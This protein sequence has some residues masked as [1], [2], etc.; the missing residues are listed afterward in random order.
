MIELFS[1]G[2][3]RAADSL[4]VL[5]SVAA[6]STITTKQVDS[7]TTSAAGI[8][9]SS[10][11]QSPFVERLLKRTRK[12]EIE[13]LC[14]NG[15]HPLL[16]DAPAI[17]SFFYTAGAAAGRFIVQR[18]G[19]SGRFAIMTSMFDRRESNESIRGFRDNL[20]T[21]QYRW[22]QVNIITCQQNPHAFEYYKRMSRFGNRTIWFWADSCEHLVDEIERI[23]K[24]NYF[25]AIKLDV[26]PCKISKENNALM[27]AI[28]LKDYQHMGYLAVCELVNPKP[29]QD[30]DDPPNIDCGCRIKQSTT[31]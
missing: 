15:R 18:F 23:K 3:Q 9:V 30:I 17:D 20:L 1:S 4:G 25:I 5:V 28:V 31:N 6:E 27:D 10:T 14:I 26:D 8:G 7:L 16:P 22:T 2:A 11:M 13:L 21:P 29:M 24:D 19:E 12:K